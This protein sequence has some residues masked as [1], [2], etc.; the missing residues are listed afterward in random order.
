MAFSFTGDAEY[1][2]PA[3]TARPDCWMAYD[4]T[5][6]P[7]EPARPNARWRHHEQPG[8]YLMLLWLIN[9]AE[10]VSVR[11]TSRRIPV[12]RRMCGMP[13]PIYSTCPRSTL[14]CGWW[15]IAT[16]TCRI[17]WATEALR[18][19]VARTELPGCMSAKPGSSGWNQHKLAAKAAA[20]AQEVSGSRSSHRPGR[21]LRRG[22]GQASASR[23][24]LRD[25]S[26]ASDLAS[27]LGSP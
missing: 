16:R 20:A 26:R 14:P 4:R 11:P 10:A 18:L 19:R 12:T 1:E 6:F 22:P 27:K 7:K 15:V 9:G 3:M 23:E 21:P 8:R 5:L 25:E 2:S 24:D 13:Q 17:G